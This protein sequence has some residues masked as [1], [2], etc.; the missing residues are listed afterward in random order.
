MSRRVSPTHITT[1]ITSAINPTMLR[2]MLIVVPITTSV[3]AIA[4]KNGLMLGPGRCSCSPAG[5]A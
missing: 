3:I 5:G 2:M 4:V 1:M